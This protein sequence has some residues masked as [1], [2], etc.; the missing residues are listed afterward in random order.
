MEFLEEGWVSFSHCYWNL[1][2][3]D[4]DHCLVLVVGFVPF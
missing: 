2:W 1:A 4:Y 3:S